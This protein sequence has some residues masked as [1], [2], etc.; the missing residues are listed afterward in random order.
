MHVMPQLFGTGISTLV[1]AVGIVAF[2][3]RLGIAAFWPVPVAFAI[4]AAASRAVRRKVAAKEERRLAMANG[5]QEYL[6]CAQEIRATNQSS[7]PSCG[8]WAASW[9][10]SSGR[11][12]PRNF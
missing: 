6:D 10:T 7:A 8:R 2:D 5:V 4:F 1:M 3:W 11:R 12:W 9:T